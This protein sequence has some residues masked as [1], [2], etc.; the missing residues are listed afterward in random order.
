MIWPLIL[1]SYSSLF[2]FGISDNIR[3]PLFPEILKDF[4]LSDA[5]GSLMF[6]LS[7]LSGFVAS[8]FTR[9]LLRRFDRRSILQGGC[10]GLTFTLLAMAFAPNFYIF[11]FFSV[12]FGLNSGIL[13]LI[14][15]VLVPLGASPEKKQQLLSGLHAMYGVASLLAPLLV[16]LL[17]YF[18]LSWRYTYAITSLAPL[19]LFIYSLHGSHSPHHSKPKLATEEHKAQRKVNFRPQVFLAFMV[20][21]AVAA[22]IMISSRLALYMRR[23]WNYDLETSSLYVTYFFISLLLGRLL[24]TGVKFKHSLRLQLSMCL[25]LTGALILLGLFI[26]PLF[27]AAAGFAIAPFYP[28]AISFISG[29]FPH[30]LDTAISYMMATD[31]MMLAFMHVLIGKLSDVYGIHNA[32][33]AGIFFLT[34]SFTLVNSYSFF[35]KKTRV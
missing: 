18:T 21:F 27:L 1:L 34:L 16:A 31:S 22:E 32:M 19:L 35:F 30:D 15:N 10:L 14:P 3:G 7:S 6:A 9:H 29:E 13:G 8:Y 2:V 4:H 33:F 20:S 28:L 17:G 5:M 12:L 26:H 23:E 11:L 25:I 24:F